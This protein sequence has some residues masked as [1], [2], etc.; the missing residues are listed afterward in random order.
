SG[1]GTPS[2][3]S[4]KARGGYPSDSHSAS[5]S[6]AVCVKNPSVSR[7]FANGSTPSNERRPKLVLNPVTPQYDAG[8]STEPPVC[9]P[10]A[11]GTI[12]A[13][14]AAPEPLDE[15]PGVC[16]ALCGLVVMFG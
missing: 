15:P 1:S 8:R 12:R 2:S 6:A 11:T 5:V 3:K 4:S 16:A 7:L 13:A 10:R 9:V 14:T